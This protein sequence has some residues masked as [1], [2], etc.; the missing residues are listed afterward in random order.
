MTRSR[1]I[2]L[3]MKTPEEIRQILFRELDA[4]PRAQEERLAPTDAVGRVLSR[5]VHARVS[6]PGFH[7][8]AMDGAAVKA[9]ATFG[10]TEASPRV[11]EIGSQAVF[12]NTGHVLPENTDAVIMIE[13]IQV[14]D[15]HHIRIEAPVFPWQHVRRMGEDIVATELLFARHHQITP[16]CVGALLAGGIREVAVIAKPHLFLVPTGPELIDYEQVASELPR[17]RVIESN[18]HVLGKM[19]EACG[20]RYT[21]HDIL[22]DD[23]ARIRRIVADAAAS[24]DVDMI[25]IMGGSSAGTEDFAREVIDSLGRVLVHG[26]AMMPGKPTV[27]GEIN[28]KPVFG[29]PGYP[30]SAI[31]AFEQFVAPLV[32]AMLG[33]PEPEPAI[34][35]ARPTRKIPGKL[36]LDQFVRV[37][38]GEV[39]G[40][41]VATPL[42]RGAGTITSI[43]EADGIIRIPPHREGIRDDESVPA[44]LL[45]SWKSVE[46]TI[47]AVGSHDNTLD[48]LADL[49]R[50]KSSRFTLSSSHV[51][52]MGGLMAVKGGLCHFAGSHLLD[53]ADGSY[54]VSYIQRLLPDTPVRLVRLVEREQGLIVAPG[55][56]KNISG[57]RDLAEKDLVFI[58]RQGGSGTR[59]LLDHHLKRAGIHPAAIQGYE[60]EE[61]THMAVAV[62][63]LGGTADAGLGIH[64]AAKALGLGFVPVAK[65]SYDLVIP[66]AFA[67]TPRIRLLLEV[68]GSGEFARRVNE[69][70]GYDTKNT[71]KT[72]WTSP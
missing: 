67:D 31:M 63:V 21:R 12:V 56:P 72:V 52:S 13:D 37:K 22:P 26:A 29:I 47:V 34:V 2:Y 68:V 10:A 19:T 28:G 44:R 41:I 43:T 53:V 62:A 3:K 54:N 60:N 14:I 70:G 51:G 27:I 42:P 17:G 57:I 20:G 71:G 8:A 69:L 49:I 36:G 59:V 11:L 33:Q 23:P 4:G 24:R 39:A 50:A 55:N 48:V 32:A 1:N 5:P 45:K 30:V 40:K 65:E 25:L 35:D 38:L 46:N 64:A 7:A 66:E 6:S 9:Q 61:F 16:Y 18:S 58:N 15:D